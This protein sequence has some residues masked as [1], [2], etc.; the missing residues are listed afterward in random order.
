MTPVDATQADNAPA[1]NA[2]LAQACRDGDRQVILPP[3]RYRVASQIVQPPGTRLQG[4]PSAY[5]WKLP[6]PAYGTVLEV[7]WGNGDG[8]AG[9]PRRAAILLSNGSAVRGVGFD[10][11]A[12]DPERDTPIEYGSTIQVRDLEVGNYDQVIADCFFHR[13]Y[14]AIDARGSRAGGDSPVAG[15]HVVGCKGSPLHAG[16]MIDSMVDWSTIRDNTF[17]AGRVAP[18]PPEALK[19][20]LVAWAAEQGAVARVGGNDWLALNDLQA[21][22]YGQGIVIAARDGYGASGPYTLDNCQ[23]D[24][25]RYSVTLSGDFAQSVLITNSKFTPF[26]AVTGTA[27]RALRGLP[28]AR[29]SGFQYSGNYIFAPAEAIVWLGGDIDVQDALITG[30]VASNGRPSTTNAAV[31]IERGHN[32]QVTGNI[33]RGFVGP[34]PG[35]P[36]IYIGPGVSGVITHDNQG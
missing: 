5:H 33:F 20:G 34:V 25:C 8:A 1:I 28:G 31:T 19:R 14:V 21:W 22:G 7:V 11:P 6:G 10:Y 4:Y 32:V 30:N 2:A 23:L 29:L 18:W 3:G 24:A 16:L 9:D 36:P 12:Q 13:S 35:G 27:G 17:N 15:L 26:N